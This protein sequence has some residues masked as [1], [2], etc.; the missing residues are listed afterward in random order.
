MTENTAGTTG[1]RLSIL[2]D[3]VGRLT[4]ELAAVRDALDAIAAEPPPPPAPTVTPTLLTVEQAAE[5]LGLSRTAV[6][7][8]IA[9]GALKSI[10]IGKRRRV[11]AV[12]ADEYVAR[13]L[14]G[15]A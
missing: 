2:T 11:P 15:A 1:T 10:Q 6:Y 5:R 7:A 3:T 4:A 8:L 9:D 12:A 14:N 13:L